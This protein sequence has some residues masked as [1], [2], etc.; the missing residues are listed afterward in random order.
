MDPVMYVC[1][2]DCGYEETEQEAADRSYSENCPDCGGL[3][4][5]AD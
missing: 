1:G 3:M 5:G 4:M 2:D